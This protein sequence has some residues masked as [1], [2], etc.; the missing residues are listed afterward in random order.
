MKKILF[1]V[2]M[3]LFFISGC[4]S[5]RDVNNVLF[6]VM[7]IVDVNESNQSVVYME[8]F[9]G[10]YDQEV[11][12]EKGERIIL[13]GKGK[14]VVDAISHLHHKATYK[15][16]GAHNKVLIFTERAAKVGLENY[17]DYFVRD[18]DF[19]LRPYLLIYKGEPM[20]LLNSKNDQTRYLGLF[21]EQLLK[22]EIAIADK[23]PKRLY[24][25]MNLR[26][27]GSRT[28]VLDLL[29][30]KDEV[31]YKEEAVILVNDK[32]VETLNED[33]LIAYNT[34]MSNTDEGY[35]SISYPL[36]KEKYVSLE[37][38]KRAIA[39][40]I[41]YSG[42]EEETIHFTK[43]IKL[44]LA[45]NETQGEID[46]TDSKIRSKII[47]EVKGKITK[48]SEELFN[49]YKKKNLDIFGVQEIFNR[50]YPKVKLKDVIENAKLKINVEVIFEGSPDTEAFN[51]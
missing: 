41:E 42:N 17:I 15:V 9:R 39:T 1:I 29:T 36:D 47:Q 13:Y 43:N 45:F 27:I 24:E 32:L 26:S 19:L 31:F 25:Y 50:K 46:L 20:D 49:K 30:V 18:Q 34:M 22:N 14:T 2:T 33:E 3:I 28:V 8:L 11:A 21:F 10:L 37:V 23:E 4:S 40:N 35:I 38:L 5:Y 16:D 44:K 48:E 51:D 12:D 6:T 7:T